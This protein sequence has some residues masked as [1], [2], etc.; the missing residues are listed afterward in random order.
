M[1]PPKDPIKRAAYIKLLSERAKKQ[2]ISPESR[3]K[4][5]DSLRG[6]KH[7]EEHNFKI[8]LSK[9]GKKRSPFSE[10]WLKKMSK[11]HKGIH[12]GKKNPQ[13][14]VTLTAETRKKL[15]EARKGEKNPRFGKPVPKEVRDKISDSVS[16]E[17][18]PAW[19]GGI[20]FEPYC[21]KF[22]DEFKNRV[23]AFFG[24]VCVECGKTQNENGKKLPVHHVNFRKDSCCNP[25]APR[26]FVPLC[27]HCHSK[28]NHNRIFWEY[29]FTEMIKRVYG[30]KCF[31]TKEEMGE[32]K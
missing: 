6:Y 15:S 18:S 29:W 14:G 32:V 13:Y 2:V 3:K 24:Y 26:L 16:G 28:T 27:N 5:A 10:T 23:R 7:T 11:S 20:S 17:R 19:K 25:D 8:A 1:P 9:Q 30:G 22:N 21:I 4:Q 31:F 12:A